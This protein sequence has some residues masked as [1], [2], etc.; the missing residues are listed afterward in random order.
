MKDAL[1][2]V[3]Q[4]VASALALIWSK[5]RVRR[6][7]HRAVRFWNQLNTVSAPL[8][9]VRYANPKERETAMSA[10]KGRPLRVV[11]LRKRGP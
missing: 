11:L 10:G 9:K 8:D 3:Y 5:I 1:V 4:P 7:T 2:G 6:D